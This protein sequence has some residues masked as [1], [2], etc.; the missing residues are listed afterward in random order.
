ML[1]KKPFMAGTTPFGCGQCL[2]CRINRARQ[3][4]WRQYLESLGHEDNA[5]ITLTYATEHLPPSLSL[6]PQHLT[7]WLKRLRKAVYPR[8]FRYFAVGEYGDQTSRPHY[9]LSLF[10]LAGL[11]TPIGRTKVAHAGIS[12]T[13]WRTW[14]LGR[15]DTQPFNETTAQYVCGYVVKKLTRKDDPRLNGRRPEFA[16]MSRRPGLGAYASQEI[17]HTLLT[18]GSAYLTENGDVPTTLRIGPKTVPL[19][20][21]MLQKLREGVG[22]TPEQIA[23]IKQKRGHESGLEL[24]S[25]FQTALNNKTA[26]TS[27]EV[28]L[29]NAS[30]RIA[31]VETKHKIWKKRTSI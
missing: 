16:T 20:R 28:Y 5:F 2:P 24:L 12:E 22:Y 21:Y 29:T 10:G 4:T 17:A 9:H 7:L 11:T 27:K 18:H 8:T 30:Q 13:I 26:L 15:T 14:G 31:Q 1:C 23:E 6:D 25:L 19:S 3:W